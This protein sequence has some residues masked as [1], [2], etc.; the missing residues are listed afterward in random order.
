MTARSIA[1]LPAATFFRLS[2]LALAA[3]SLSCAT[4]SGNSSRAAEPSSSGTASGP[5][6]A[7][8]FASA[9]SRQT[10][11]VVLVTIDGMRWQEVFGGFEL[12]VLE[13]GTRLPDPDGLRQRY[14]RA[15]PELRRQALMPFFW[16]TVAREGQIFGEPG[17]H[18]TA[19]VT[20]GFKFSY[21]GYN[22]MLS[23]YPDPRIDSNRQFP[24]PNPNVL[25]FLAKRPG[26]DG[27]VAAYGTWDRLYSIVNA[28][29]SKFFVQAGW[30]PI[31]DEPLTERQRELNG[32][33][34]DLPRIWPDNT[35]DSFIGRAAMEHL[36]RHKPRVM[37][38]MLGE[39]DEWAHLHRYDCYLD[40]A[41]LNDRWIA[42]LWQWLQSDPQYAGKTSL[43][44]TTDHGRG[45]TPSDWGDH[46]KDTPGAEDIWMA[47]IGPDTPPLGVR[48]DVA[49]TQGQIAATLAAL[50][51]EEYRAAVPKA[52]P[53]LPGVIGQPEPGR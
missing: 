42:E 6:T 8:T 17:S 25:E 52:A 43:V 13:Q 16:E 31:A 37:Y 2:L 51:G 5:T 22:E 15:T 24:N 3:V 36:R 27:K 39:T 18:S 33:L 50:L 19:R 46:G 48:R 49:V 53:P 9:G 38:V 35:F 1:R 23:G 12:R 21:P 14:A 26:F 47:V 30:T 7:A 41:R 4:P 28:E 29:R 32:W 44:I 10:Q 40:A 34:A 11:N 20:N 45:G